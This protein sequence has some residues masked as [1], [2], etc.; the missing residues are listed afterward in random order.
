MSLINNLPS[1]YDLLSPVAFR[2]DV[3]RL[4]TVTFFAQSVSLPGIS[5]EEDTQATPFTD[6]PHPGFKVSFETLEVNFLID[7]DLKNYTELMNWIIGLGFP[8]KFEQYKDLKNQTDATKG[9]SA[10]Y[11]AEFNA[12][13]S[14][15]TL[16][17]LTNTKNV[18]KQFRF[19]ELFPISL[20]AIAFD[21]AGEDAP[22]LATA[23]FQYTDYY[24]ES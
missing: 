12:V 15:A 11:K 2:F 20:S 1:N 8:E 17:I 18:N 16:S 22:I 21:S 10:K 9:I 6:I 19:R 5:L 14:D 4:P 7:E 3:L 23:S 13:K 24:L